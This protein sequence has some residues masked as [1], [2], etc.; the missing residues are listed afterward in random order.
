M[1]YESLLAALQDRDAQ[2]T[3]AC[4]LIA[5]ALIGMEREMRGKPAGIRTHT[6][7][8]FAAALLTM[9][10]LR[11]ESWTAELPV[12]TQLVSDM[13]RL[14]HAILTGVGFL[15]AGV[16][17]REGASVQGLTTA[18]TLWLTAALG[19]VFGTGLLELGI[20]GTV[21]ALLVLAL[22]RVL[23]RLA[24]PSPSLRLELE[25]TRS[26][27]DGLA[28]IMELLRREGLRPGPASL[29]QRRG[30]DVLSYALVLAATGGEIDAPA[31]AARL[32][33]EPGVRA[34][35]LT[36]LDPAWGEEA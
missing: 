24:P 25:L 21:V 19:V 20:L 23:Q 27:G 9:V 28:R 15:G 32:E 22:L 29:R 12:G 3:I 17:F 11:M 31:L 2:L 5:G 16:I 18:A 8:C 1:T 30:E 13:A 14:P 4:S 6:L 33:T 10:G 36:Q 35:A 26:P 7:L 34:V